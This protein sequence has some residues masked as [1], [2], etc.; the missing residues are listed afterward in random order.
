ME[1]N[2][3]IVHLVPDAGNPCAPLV[4]AE[5]HHLY[6]YMYIIKREE[7]EHNLYDEI[8]CTHTNAAKIEREQF[9]EQHTLNSPVINRDTGKIMF[10]GHLYLL[11]RNLQITCLLLLVMT[12][13]RPAFIIYAIYTVLYLL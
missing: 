3:D 4:E 6:M 12:S 13:L 2:V 5:A 11:M 1:L 8:A 7:E 10:Y 9:H